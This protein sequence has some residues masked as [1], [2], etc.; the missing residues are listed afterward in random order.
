[1]KPENIKI[2]NIVVKEN[3]IYGLGDDNMI[4]IWL[5]EKHMWQLWA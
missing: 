2:I 5:A 4:Y 3:W 1:M